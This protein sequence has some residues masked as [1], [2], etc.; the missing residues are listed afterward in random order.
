M[1][2]E[3]LQVKENAKVVLRKVAYPEREEEDARK[4]RSRR[5]EKNI[6]GYEED[7]ACLNK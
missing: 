5:K 3:M 1:G 2:K 7:Y 6:K 4:K